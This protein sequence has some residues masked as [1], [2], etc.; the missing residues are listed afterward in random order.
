MHERHEILGFLCRWCLLGLSAAG[1]LAL[2]VFFFRSATPERT[3]PCMVMSDG[4]WSGA[5]AID[6]RCR[7]TDITVH[8]SVPYLIGGVPGGTW[9]II[10]GRWGDT[11]FWQ[12]DAA[13]GRNPYRIRGIPYGPAGFAENTSHFIR[14]APAERLFLL[15]AH[16]VL[17]QRSDDLRRLMEV[18]SSRGRL[19]LISGDSASNVP[20]LRENLK[21]AGFDQTLLAACTP[22]DHW[23]VA[24]GYVLQSAGRPASQIEF[25]TADPTVAVRA[26]QA[27][28]EVDLVAAPECWPASRPTLREF[29]GLANLQAYLA[30]RPISQ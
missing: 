13:I 21:Q 27:G 17:Q 25:I 30:A 18:I 22:D 10:S 28:F 4:L 6:L 19:V 7:L 11:E 29:S 3:S 15:D 1:V 2:V 12:P 20:K 5:G 14:L 23:G 26:S 24:F 8:Q 9:Q 16:L